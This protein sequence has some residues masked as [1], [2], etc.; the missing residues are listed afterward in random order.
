MDLDEL[1]VD[2]DALVGRA[3]PTRGMAV[4]VGHGPASQWP[5]VDLVRRRGVAAHRRRR[6]LVSAAAV[7]TAVVVGTAVLM[8]AAGNGPNA[9][10]AVLEQAASASAGQP[11]A[12]LGPG[13]Y[14][15]TSTT[16]SYQVTVYDP[17]PGGAFVDVATARYQ[18]T[19]QSWLDA[20]G[21]GR[22]ARHSSAYQFGSAADE[23]AWETDPGGASLSGSLGYGSGPKTSDGPVREGSL[24]QVGGLPTDPGTLA[25]VLAAGRDGT[26]GTIQAGAA[27]AVFER[28]ARLL[29]GP[30]DGMT[31]ALAS[32][33]YQ[34]M[35]AQA[36]ITLVGTA[37]AHDGRIGTGVALDVA[38]GV[39][40][41]IVDPTTGALLEAQFAPPPTSLPKADMDFGR[42]CASTAPGGALTCQPNV[43]QSDTV[44]GPLWI[45]LR[46]RVVVTSDTATG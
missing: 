44:A 3:D 41:V 40:E 21:T 38:T 31:P 26:G 10:A 6:V 29:V 27:A 25:A 8:P 18:V 39:N 28:A 23:Q 34:V 43:P 30:V 2:L 33:L 12:A 46:T 42:S 24:P 35:A 32:A 16:S 17:Q 20:S 13:Q 1:T 19:T 7:T 4:P 5:H 37:T 14:Q 11:A 36:G 45:D 22:V 9:A 15:Y